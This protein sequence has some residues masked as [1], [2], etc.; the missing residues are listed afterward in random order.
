[1]T[2]KDEDIDDPVVTNEPEPDFAELA[3]AALDNAGIN[4]NKRIQDAQRQTAAPESAL[5]E[6]AAALVKNA[7]N[8]QNE[9]VYEIIF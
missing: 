8:A 1:M 2:L 7:H 9:I 6:P 3:T 5:V 4:A